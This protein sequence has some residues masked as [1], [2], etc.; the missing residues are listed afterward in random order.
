MFLKFVCFCRAFFKDPVWRGFIFF[1]L[2]CSDVALKFAYFFRICFSLQFGEALP[3]NRVQFW[4]AFPCK[5]AERIKISNINEPSSSHLGF[6]LRPTPCASMHIYI[7]IYT[8]IYAV[9]LLTGPSLAIFKVINWAKSKFQGHFRTIKIG[10]Q[11]IFL[12][13]C[14]CVFVWCPIF[15]QF[16]KN[17]LFFKKRVQRLGFS[18]FSV[19]I[20]NFEILIF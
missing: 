6:V 18:S 15:W 11:A 7:Y 9:E 20:L 19:L 12:L 16:S 14:H 13:S 8:H 2:I 10:F 1:G 5:T 3:H 17:S 4:G